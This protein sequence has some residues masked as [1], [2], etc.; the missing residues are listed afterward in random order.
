MLVSWCF[1][2]SRPKR[3]IS[4]LKET[5]IKRYIIE[6]TYQAEMR[7]EE[8]RKRRVVG[9]TI[10]RTIMMFMIITISIMMMIVMAE[11]TMKC[12]RNEV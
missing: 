7:P 4:G 5:F 8:Q 11:R 12:K 6:R 1:E 9:T 3:I 10:M 2:P